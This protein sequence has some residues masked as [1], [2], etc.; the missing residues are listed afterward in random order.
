ME[1]LEFQ[2]RSADCVIGEFLLPVQNLLILTMVKLRVEAVLVSSPTKDFQTV[3]KINRKFDTL[4]T[5]TGKGLTFKEF[6][7]WHC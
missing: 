6:Y 7:N 4:F 1:I 3:Y 2:V 5:I